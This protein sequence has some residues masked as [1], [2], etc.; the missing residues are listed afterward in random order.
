GSAWGAA[1]LLA[2]VGLF[3]ASFPMLVAHG[4]AFFPP[5]LVGRGVTLLN[6]CS[7]GGVG[8]AQSVSA[9]VQAATGFAGLFL[10]FALALVAG[11]AIYL[12]AADRTD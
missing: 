12:L 7:I 2:G 5:H 10:F 9:P 11:C 1:A 6:L 3:G 4:R 8:V